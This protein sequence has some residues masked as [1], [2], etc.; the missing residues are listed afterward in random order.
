MSKKDKKEEIAVETGA[1]HTVSPMKH[2]MD[3][4]GVSEERARQAVSDINKEARI[5]ENEN[6]LATLQAKALQKKPDWK[7]FKGG[8]TDMLHGSITIETGFDLEEFLIEMWVVS[9]KYR[10]GIPGLDKLIADCGIIAYLAMYKV[11]KIGL[12]VSAN[13]MVSPDKNQFRIRRKR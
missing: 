1:E 4:H 11:T 6:R 12:E 8:S 5:N 2:L 13:N 3:K 10:F 7:Y 9:Q